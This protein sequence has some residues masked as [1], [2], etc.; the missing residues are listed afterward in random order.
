MFGEFGFSIAVRAALTAILL[1]GTAFALGGSIGAVELIAVLILASRSAKLLM[2]ESAV[3]YSPRPI[4][5]FSTRWMQFST[6]RRCLD[7]QA[8][9]RSATRRLGASAT[10]RASSTRFDS[11]TTSARSFA[12]S[13]S[14]RHR[15]R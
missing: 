12:M 13:V 10:R 3:A 5:A 7:V 6:P 9:S 15:E 4:R 8:R 11:A 2:D 14:S 1:A